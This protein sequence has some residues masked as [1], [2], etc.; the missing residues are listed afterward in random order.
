MSNIQDQIADMLTRIRNAQAAFKQEVTMPSSK[1]KVAIAHLLKEEGYISD[2]QVNSHRSGE[3]VLTILLKYFQG[4]PVIR[5]IERVSR[6]GVKVYKKCQEI[7]KVMGGLGIAIVSTSK[8]LL[9]DHQA[10]KLN[11]GGEVICYVE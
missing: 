5:S 4:E 3:L 9:T 6:P 1:K 8:G 10:R 2:Y 11:L 7:P